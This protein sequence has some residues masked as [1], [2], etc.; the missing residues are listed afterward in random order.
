M[1]V[2][3]TPVGMRNA[4]RGHPIC[5]RPES[6]CTRGNSLPTGYSPFYQDLAFHLSEYFG[7]GGSCC[8]LAI[9]PIASN[10]HIGG[11]TPNPGWVHLSQQFIFAKGHQAS[12]P[13]IP[14]VEG[15]L[16][17][18]RHDPCDPFRVVASDEAQDYALGGAFT[19]CA[20]DCR[21]PLPRGRDHR[22][23]RGDSGFAP[24]YFN[25]PVWKIYTPHLLF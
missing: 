25:S 5:P 4:R 20:G 18:G 16:A 7:V 8:P 10:K 24:S 23:G 2:F 15:V 22:L 13:K 9:F 14:P 12:Q 6:L 17:F 19:Y 3:C 21:T 11:G 1:V